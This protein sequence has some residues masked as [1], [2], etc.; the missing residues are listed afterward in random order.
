MS[1]GR[2]GRLFGAMSAH[3]FKADRTDPRVHRFVGSLEASGKLVDISI[4]FASCDITNLPKVRL[5]RPA[6]QA[7]DVVA[8]LREDQF[9]YAQEGDGNVVLDPYEVEKSVAV[10]MKILSREL[11]RAL[12]RKK[13]ADEIA[14]EFQQHWNGTPVFCALPDGWSGQASMHMG[15]R[16]GRGDVRTLD[17][18]EEALRRLIPEQGDLAESRRRRI[19]AF[20]LAV[21]NDLTL[22]RGETQPETFG[23]FLDWAE[24]RRPGAREETIQNLAE[25][26]WRTK[27]RAAVFLHGRNA[28]VGVEVHF[29]SIPANAA[30]RSE[31]LRRLIELRGDDNM[32]KRLAGYPVDL[33]HVVS[34][35]L[36]GR[37]HLG[38]RRLA[39]VGCGTIGSHLARMLVQSGA[40]LLGGVLTLIDKDVMMPENVGR[41]LLGTT[42]ILEHKAT[43]VAGELKRHIPDVEVETLVQDASVN[44][45]RLRLFDLVIDATGEEGLSYALNDA[46]LRQRTRPDGRAPDVLYVRLFGNGAAGQCLLVDGAGYACFKCLRPRHGEPWRFDPLR[47]GVGTVVQ[48]AACGTGPFVAYGVAA[49]TMAAALALQAVLDWAAG[50][51]SPRLRTVRVEQAATCVVRD[52]NPSRASGCP[53]C[54]GSA[55]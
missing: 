46:F 35:N 40:G 41:H 37:A 31:G 43:A 49:P 20:V 28:L 16:A 51:P 27:R 22:L 24:R 7:P 12:S 18:Q 19:P 42:S 11:E 25:M 21:D 48:P 45:D 32:V 5:L 36:A 30:Q 9:C 23:A 2:A 39:L 6:E 4:E 14:Q 50:D 33:K 3:G 10:I 55:V 8:H 29:R 52:K 34:R 17:R 13:V 47:Q 15:S 44:T 1:Q 53:A 26:L 38:G 54:G